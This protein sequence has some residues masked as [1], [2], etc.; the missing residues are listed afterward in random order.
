MARTMLVESK[1]PKKFWDEAVN[2]TCHILN[3]AMVRPILNRTPYELLK[4]K[5][6]NVSYFKLF[7]VKY[8]V[9]NNNKKN[10]DKFDFKSE[11]GYF[12]RYSDNSRSY[13]VFHV[14]NN[15]VE[16]SSHVLFEESTADRS[17]NQDFDEEF[18]KIKLAKENQGKE[19]HL[20]GSIAE[21]SQSDD[22]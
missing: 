17:H 7:G 14:K 3:R 12:L 1:L 6:F 21:A 8:F 16:E 5:K 22:P 4:G 2:T 18:L 13:R 11:L 20:Q 10:L 15:C 9:H 19:Q